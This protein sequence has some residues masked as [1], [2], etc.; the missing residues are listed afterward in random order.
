MKKKIFFILISVAIL[1]ISILAVRSVL[2]VSGNNKLYKLIEHNKTN[3]AITLIS[4]MSEEDVNKYSLPLFLNR[5]ISVLSQGMW[6]VEIPLVKACENGNYKIIEALLKKGADPNKY[7]DGGWTPIEAVFVKH[8]SNRFEIAKL[9]IE[10]G[11][12]VNM[13]GSGSPALFSE[14]GL[15]FWGAKNEELSNE[16]ITFLIDNGAE[17][18]NGNDNYS[19]LHYSAH[20]NNVLISDNLINDYHLPIDTIN[21][22]G[23]TPL[24]MS[25][26]NNAID[27]AKLLLEHG[28]D[29]FIKDT[30]GKTAYDLAVEVGNV[31]MAKLLLGR[32]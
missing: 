32:D 9:L 18:V 6:R 2:K 17:T 22:N 14:A 10:Y 31:E 19:I 1:S 11:A 15:I 5:P 12:D 29:R 8:H 3:E 30:N 28:A 24:M 7:I 16:I 4:K 27:T 25:A 13:C 26:K 21:I 23:Q 20:G